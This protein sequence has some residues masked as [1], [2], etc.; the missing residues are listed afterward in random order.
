M[1][2]AEELFGSIAADVDDALSLIAPTM[3]F[4]LIFW[5]KGRHDDQKA[6]AI[7]TAPAGQAD[8]VSALKTALDA[9]A[10]EQSHER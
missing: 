4:S 3:T 7:M 8:L 2:R 10:Q 5:V 6:L 9:L 1:S